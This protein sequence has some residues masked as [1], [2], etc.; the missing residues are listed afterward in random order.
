MQLTDRTLNNAK[1]PAF[2][3]FVSFFNLQAPNNIIVLPLK[4]KSAISSYWKYF[5]SLK[6]SDTLQFKT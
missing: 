1:G 4:C 5:R 6:Q 2:I 3:S